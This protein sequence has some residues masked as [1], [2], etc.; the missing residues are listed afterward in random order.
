MFPTMSPTKDICAWV[1][2]AY[3]SKFKPV[4]SERTLV[5]FTT[6]IEII[7]DI[8]SGSFENQLN[9]TAQYRYL[10]SERIKA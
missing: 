2:H 1:A 5:T 7:F 3:V 4:G 6:N 8:S 10:L 9:R